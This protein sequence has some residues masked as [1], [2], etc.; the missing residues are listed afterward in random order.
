MQG[1]NLQAHSRLAPLCAAFDGS[2][3]NADI[4]RAK[5][6]LIATDK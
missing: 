4:E 5:T 1:K 6:L 2:S 3:V